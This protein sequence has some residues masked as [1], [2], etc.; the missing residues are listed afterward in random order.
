MK[1]VPSC[2]MFLQSDNTN[3]GEPVFG[4]LITDGS[5]RGR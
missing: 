4:F 1:G 3:P 5:I 2:F